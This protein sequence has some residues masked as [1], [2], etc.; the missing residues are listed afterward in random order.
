MWP[1]TTVHTCVMHL[2]R[3]TFRLSSR[4]RWD[5]L[6]HDL[7]AIYTAPTEAA[8]SADFDDL[9]DCWGKRYPTIIRLWNNAWQEFIPYLDYDIEIRQVLRSTNAIES[10][11]ARY[12]R[13][14][15][16]RWHF[17]PRLPRS[18]ASTW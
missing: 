11:N 9:A 15:K 17:P 8:A 4:Q 1:A 7:K 10:L 2:I 6:E 13:S 12:R 5:A 18:N 14:V 16:A 3:I